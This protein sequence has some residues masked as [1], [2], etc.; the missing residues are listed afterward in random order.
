MPRTAR[1][2]DFG[3][4]ATGVVANENDWGSS[5]PRILAPRRMVTGTV[6][7]LYPQAPAVVKVQTPAGETCCIRITAGRRPR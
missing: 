5:G 1:R 6:V 7:G 3:D 2:Y 4:T